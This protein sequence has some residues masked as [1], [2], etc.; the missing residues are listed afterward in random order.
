[1]LDSA[2]VAK[3]GAAKEELHNL[4]AKPQLSGIPVREAND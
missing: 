4:M 2:D 1:M 3:M